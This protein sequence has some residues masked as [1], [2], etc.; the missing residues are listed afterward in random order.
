MD[1]DPTDGSAAVDPGNTG[2][3]G[4]DQLFRILT[5]GPAQDE[6]AGERGALAMFRANVSPVAGPAPVNGT[7]VSGTTVP[8]Q[9]G[10][11]ATAPKRPVRHPI[12]MPVRWGVRLAAAVV[13]AIGG[14]LAGAAYEA[15]LPAPVQD[16]AHQVLGFAGVPKAQPQHHGRSPR[17]G[18]H[19][20]AAAPG[21]SSTPPG[22]RAHPSQT[23]KP[24]ASASRAASPTASPSSASTTGPAVLSESAGSAIIPAGSQPVINGQL[25]TAGTGVDGVTV[26]L[27]ERLAGRPLWH[28][29]GT[30][31]TTSGGN[32]A[33]TGPPLATNAAF[34]LRLPGG[35]HSA[36][37]LVTVTPQVT[38]VLTPGASSVRDLLTVAT[39]YARRGNVVWLQVQSVSGS[40]V[41]LRSK[42]LNAAGK[43]WFILSGKRL[44]NETVQVVLVATVRHGSATSN[45]ETVPPPA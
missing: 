2:D 31:Q 30:G 8:F 23:A 43:T 1:S 34:R 17:A 6:L 24:G 13:I 44:K 38:V 26:T 19:H 37:V 32:V 5:A 27:I 39:Q 28:V 10:G 7:P 21:R 22:G 41:D 45:P 14:A 42:R 35:V 16:L 4:I 33:I 20:A 40:W 9:A 12:R 18:G 25:T 29:V 36:S 15:A 11:R 3:P